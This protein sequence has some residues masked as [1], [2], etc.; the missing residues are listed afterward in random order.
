MASHN[1]SGKSPYV[2]VAMGKEGILVR[3]ARFPQYKRVWESSAIFP[4]SAWNELLNN[5][6]RQI[7]TTATTIEH[8]S[9]RVTI[10]YSRGSQSLDF[11]PPGVARFHERSSRRKARAGRRPERAAVASTTSRGCGHSSHCG[12]NCTTCRRPSS[13]VTGHL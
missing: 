5:I 2:E 10:A 13:L 6:S 9:D 1:G 7:P 8:H 12:I 3:D 11:T 4:R